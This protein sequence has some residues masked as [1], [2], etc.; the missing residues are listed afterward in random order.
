VVDAKV[1]KGWVVLYGPQVLYR[2][3]PHATF[4]LVFNALVRAGEKE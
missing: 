1:G 2:G 4:K 3:Q